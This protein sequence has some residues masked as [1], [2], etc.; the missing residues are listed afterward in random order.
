MTPVRVQG[1]VKFFNSDK[2]FGF[3]TR[4]GD[5][6]VFIHA[7]E[8]KRSGVEGPVKEGDQL[9]FDVVPVD[10]KGPKAQSIRRV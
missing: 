5:R 7:N 10:G 2:G 1:T 3:A 8:L 9:E 4:D 6:D